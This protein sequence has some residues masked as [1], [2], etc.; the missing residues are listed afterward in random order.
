MTTIREEFHPTDWSQFVGQDALK[1][2]LDV[3]VQA[4]RNDNRPMEHVLLVGPPGAGKSTIAYL[5][6][7]RLGD[8]IETVS[9]PLPVKQLYR[10]LSTKLH[11]GVLLVDEAHLWSAAQQHQLMS[12]AEA[13]TLDVGFD[14][15][16][17]P[18]LTLILGTTDPQ[19]L[20]PQLRE[21][22]PVTHP[23]AP[24]TD[25]EMAEMTAGFAQRACVEMDD[26]LCAAVGVA[27]AG[28]PRRARN[29]V[30][31]ARERQSCGLPID[32]AVLLPFCAVEPDGLTYDH[33]NY[34]RALEGNQSRAGIDQLA[35]RLRMHKGTVVEI[36]RLLTD[37]GMILHDSTGRILTAA[38][39]S[40]I[41]GSREF[42]D[43]RARARARGAA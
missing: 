30:I 37:R 13:G 19:E 42:N 35:R 24:Y 39:R 10:I 6:A 31:A 21:R 2:R 38:G 28:V 43:P 33:L 32:A 41:S 15:I 9:K 26:D 12:L 5:I 34:L 3:S 27:A 16:S 23:F 18:W 20:L 17:F 22:M 7:E 29:Y 14:E 25:D 1:H 8:P 4:A 40:R 36:E 11:A